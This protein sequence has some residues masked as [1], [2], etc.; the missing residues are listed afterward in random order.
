MTFYQH[1]NLHHKNQLSRH[2]PLWKEI[3]NSISISCPNWVCM[4]NKIYW[5]TPVAFCWLRFAANTNQLH[6]VHAGK[7][8]AGQP[9]QFMLWKGVSPP[10]KTKEQVPGCSKKLVSIVK[11][12]WFSSKASIF[13]I[14]FRI[15]C[16]HWSRYLTGCSGIWKLPQ[17][18]GLAIETSYSNTIFL[19]I[20]WSPFQPRSRWRKK[21]TQK[22]PFN[23]A[24]LSPTNYQHQQKL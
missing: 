24:T 22:S 3:W 19:Y 1:Q 17:N 18:L 6:L 21:N 10:K 16:F 2:M 8:S 4:F 13:R 5:W 7:L 14:M 15:M 12:P 9:I 11:I 20:W 23:R